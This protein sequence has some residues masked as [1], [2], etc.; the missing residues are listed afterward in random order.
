MGTTTALRQALKTQLYPVFE[1]NGF[2]V[3]L[4]GGPQMVTFRR[5]NEDRISIC[6]IQWD[7]YG[8]ARFALNFGCGTVDA[9]IAGTPEE[10]ILPQDSFT[11]N[12]PTCGRIDSGRD[13]GWFSEG[14]NFIGKL[15]GKKPRKPEAV[16]D[17]AVAALPDAFAFFDKGATM[18]RLKFTRKV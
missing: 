12:M 5:V 14:P 10:K 11:Y 8:T 1:E 4:R 15:F 7:K 3:D 2:T 9:I 16:A 6:D 18:P 17:E 13:G